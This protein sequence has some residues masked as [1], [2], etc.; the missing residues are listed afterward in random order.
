MFRTEDE[1]LFHRLQDGVG[2]LLGSLFDWP[3]PWEAARASGSHPAINIWEDE[4]AFH[5]EAEVPGID[6]DALEIFVIGRELTVKGE[7]KLERPEGVTEHR[8]ER[9]A[10]AFHRVVY[11]PAEVDASRVEAALRDGVLHIT[12]PKA[13]SA[14]PRKVHIR[15]EK[16]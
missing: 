8:S 2:H 9:R 11:L 13:E 16:D 4:T 3:P 5:A 10:G 12:L 1:R 15:T 6:L 7:R 14:K